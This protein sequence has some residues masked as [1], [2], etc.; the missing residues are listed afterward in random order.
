MLGGLPQPADALQTIDD[1]ED[2]RE[3]VLRM[4]RLAQRG[5]LEAFATLVA[6]DRR[7]DERTRECVLALA[8]EPFLASTEPKLG[9]RYNRSRRAI[10]SVG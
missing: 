8:T 4:A 7:L 3:V 5:R 6:A 2:L 1:D 10:S 9:R